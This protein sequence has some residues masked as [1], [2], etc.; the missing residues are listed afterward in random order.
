M[1]FE[2]DIIRFFQSNATTGWI[3]FFQTASMLGSYL[4]FLITFIIVF[5]KNK[6]LGLAVALT[7]AIGSI[8]NYSLKLLIRRPRPFDTYSDI[9][10]LGNEDG[11]SMPSGH[12]LCSGMFAT[13]LI[14]TLL[15]YSKDR[16]TK[17]LGCVAIG[18]LP[19]LVALSRMVLGVHYFTDTL[20]GITLGVLFAFF[21]IM[22]YYYLVKRLPARKGNR[23]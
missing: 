22:L 16:W 15:T 11:F 19:M 3:A 5:I 12:S 9:L 14:Y 18:L 13:F 8:I 4:G 17:G 10:N 21:A 2:Y 1:E 7:F 6:K 20:L 23:H